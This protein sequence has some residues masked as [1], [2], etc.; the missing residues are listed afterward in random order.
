MARNIVI[1]AKIRSEK[2]IRARELRRN[3]TPGEKVLWSHLRTNKFK[4][5]HFRRQQI[6]DGYIIDFYCHAAAL[7]IEVDGPVHDKQKDY[8]SER[9]QN[10][11]ARGFCILRISE[12]EVMMDV[13]TVLQKIDVVLCNKGN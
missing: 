9:D 1:G 6:I 8:D 5:F 7:I 2:R 3:M 4:G 13:D 10:L 11:L 12:N